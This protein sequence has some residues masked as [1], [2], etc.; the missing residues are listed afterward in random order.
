MVAGGCLRLKKSNFFSTFFFQHFF[1]TIFFYGHFISIF[2]KLSSYLLYLNCKT[3]VLAKFLRYYVFA[4]LKLLI[5]ISN[6]YHKTLRDFIFCDCLNNK[7]H[8]LRYYRFIFAGFF[9]YLRLQNTLTCYIILQSG[10]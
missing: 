5:F 1:A 4:I 7:H 10:K 9:A 2:Q 8:E 6:L 3:E